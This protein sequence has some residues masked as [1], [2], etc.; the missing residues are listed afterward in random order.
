MILYKTI[1]YDFVPVYESFE[2][3][4]EYHLKIEKIDK[5]TSVRELLEKADINPLNKFFILNNRTRIDANELDYV[6]TNNGYIVPILYIS[7]QYRKGR[8]YHILSFPNNNKGI[9]VSTIKEGKIYTPPYRIY[10]HRDQKPRPYGLN[11]R[12]IYNLILS[13]VPLLEAVALA[14]PN[15][16]KASMLRVASE[17]INE[18][19]I[20]KYIN[21]EDKMNLKESLLENGIT[22]NYITKKLKQILDDPKE[23]KSLKQFALQT[24]INILDKP[25]NNSIMTVNINKL[26]SA[27]LNTMNELEN[28]IKQLT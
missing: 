14:Y 23:T 10:F 22:Y 11:Y 15:M 7:T 12:F 5:T 8:D 21:T 28:K 25:D 6:H 13:G 20:K 2:E 4:T 16:K 24:S 18:E 9:I 3:Y 17:V 27:Q 19:V 26:A 1:K